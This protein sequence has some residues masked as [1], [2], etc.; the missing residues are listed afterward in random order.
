MPPKSALEIVGQG[1]L[2]YYGSI[3]QIDRFTH[4]PRPCYVKSCHHALKTPSFHPMQCSVSCL[5]NCIYVSSRNQGVKVENALEGRFHGFVHST[6]IYSC[7]SGRFI[8][9]NREV[10]RNVEAG[11]ETTTS[12]KKIST[13]D[14]RHLTATQKCDVSC[15]KFR[16]SVAK[17]ALFHAC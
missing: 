5:C 10:T 4:E 1:L 9:S 13:Q 8:S 2:C 3:Y 15:R 7:F 11:G 6:N 17:M 12:H 16:L 14:F